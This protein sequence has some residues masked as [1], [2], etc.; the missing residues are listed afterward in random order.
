MTLLTSA[1]CYSY[2]NPQLI[3]GL[4]KR[5]SNIHARSKDGYDALMFASSRGNFDVCTILLEHGAD[6][7]AASNDKLCCALY[8]ACYHGHFDV[9]L[10][11]I[12][13]GA[14]LMLIMKGD[15]IF[16]DIERG[17]DEKAK[18]CCDSLKKAFVLVR[19]GNKE[20]LL[21]VPEALRRLRLCR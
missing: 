4:L 17:E 3:E 19:T 2:D 14:N 13:R 12:S 21:F 1:C 18:Q 16:Y 7:N 6:P 5:G 9:A 10:L 8:H 15:R 20:F 11:L